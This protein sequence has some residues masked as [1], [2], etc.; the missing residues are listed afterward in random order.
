MIGGVAIWRGPGHL[1]DATFTTRGDRVDP[2]RGGRGDGAPAFRLDLLRGPRWGGARVGY[3]VEHAA[4][5]GHVCR[6]AEVREL[7]NHWPERVAIVPY[8]AAIAMLAGMAVES[9]RRNNISRNRIYIA[10]GLPVA[11]Q[12]ALVGGRQRPIP[13]TTLF[14]FTAG[15]LLVQLCSQ[16]TRWRRATLARVLMGDDHRV[17]SD[18]VV[19]VGASERSH[20][21][22]HWSISAA[23]SRQPAHRIPRGTMESEPGRYIG[24]DPSKSVYADGY[25]VL[26]RHQ[27]AEP[28]TIAILVN[29]RGVLYGIE[30]VCGY[31][32]VQPRR[33]VSI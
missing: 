29:N 25:E 8:L 24:Y 11:G 30:D 32:P 14:A 2:R 13:T 28:E 23:S 3:A 10:F 7:H 1:L 6:P 17:R 12:P 18:C 31:N 22:F 33:F 26:Y 21:G 19:F 5:L 27:F 9:L 16:T 20:G 15:L 4:P